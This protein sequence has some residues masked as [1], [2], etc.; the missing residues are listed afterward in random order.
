MLEIVEEVVLLLRGL[1]EIAED[2]VV[3]LQRDAA[4]WSSV[5]GAADVREDRTHGRRAAGCSGLAA[6]DGHAGALI[7]IGHRGNPKPVVLLRRARDFGESGAAAVPAARRGEMVEIVEEVVVL[8]LLQ[9]DR[10]SA[11]WSSVDG[12]ADVRGGRAQAQRAAGCSGLAAPDGH[13]DAVLRFGHVGAPKGVVL[14]QRNLTYAALGQQQAHDLHDEV[15]ISYLPMVRVLE[16]VVQALMFLT[17]DHVTTKMPA[18][19]PAPTI[20]VEAAAAIA[21]PAAATARS[22]RAA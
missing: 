21:T 17:L 4:C 15:Q 16:R 19:T 7:R 14:L 9:R 20:E 3:L 22:C 13:A 10:D 6:P 18:A 12:A 1:V 5:D 2:V 11:C 8:L